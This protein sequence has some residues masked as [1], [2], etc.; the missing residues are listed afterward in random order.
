[1]KK[2]RL[3]IGLAMLFIAA[4]VISSCQK[5][6]VTNED[7]ML[8]KGK[9]AQV[10][11][12]VSVPAETYP[13]EGCE[14]VC[15]EAGSGDFYSKTGSVTGSI[16]ANNKTIVYKVYNTETDFVVELSYSRTPANSGASSS[17]DVKVKDEVISNTIINGSSATYTFPL[18]AGWNACDEMVWTLVETAG[19]GTLLT[20]GG[21]YELIG[22]CL[23]DCTESFSYVDNENGS[24]TFT[25]TPAEDMEDAELI[26]TFA[27]GALDTPLEGWEF[28]GQTMQK[29]M[30][31]VACTTYKWTVILDCKGLNNPQ[32]MWTD[33]KIGE[34]SM[35]EKFNLENIKC[36]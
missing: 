30:N 33:F 32:N 35:K 9:T 11:Q 22:L 28:K 25:Y 20:S 21:S 1:M 23:S 10:V 3:F 14:A 4:A 15:I 12:T 13:A 18:D 17:I 27:Q 36:N 19:D 7:L 5:E 31:L 16:G 34:D 8:K 24:Y 2:N 6:E 26:F 29:T